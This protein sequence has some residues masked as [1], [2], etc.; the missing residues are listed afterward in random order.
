VITG[1]RQQQVEQAHGGQGDCC[2]L[3]ES[4]T[5]RADGSKDGLCRANTIARSDRIVLCTAASATWSYGAMAL[6]A[7]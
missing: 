1:V 2:M 5:I 4:R 3:D 7:L 6:E